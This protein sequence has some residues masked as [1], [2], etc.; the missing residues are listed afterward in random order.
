MTNSQ[1]CK[2]QKVRHLPY[3]TCPQATR[4]PKS[5]KAVKLWNWGD[6]IRGWPTSDTV[7]GI[8]G[9]TPIRATCEIGRDADL[10]LVKLGETLIRAFVK[11]GETLIRAF[12]KLGETLIRAP[13]IEILSNFINFLSTFYQLF[14]NF[15]HQ[16]FQLFINFLST[17][18]QLFINFYQ[19]LST[20]YQ[21]LSTFYQL[22][23]NFLSTFYQCFINF[24]INFLSTCFINFLSTW[25]KWSLLTFCE[26]LFALLPGHT[27]FLV[28]PAVAEPE[29]D[30]VLTKKKAWLIRYPCTANLMDCMHFRNWDEKGTKDTETVRHTV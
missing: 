14:I 24:F 26:T 23:I 9:E 11:L 5:Q 29:S 7:I 28:L 8:S 22:F 25:K 2:S 17:F 12:V 18:Y 1:Y 4:K 21:L 20:F 30:Q 13:K 19:L 27:M 3:Q 16:L 6:G 10:T 15:F